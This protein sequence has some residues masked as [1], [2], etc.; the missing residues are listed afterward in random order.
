MKHPETEEHLKLKEI[1]KLKLAEWFQG[2]TLK[3]YMVAGYEADVYGI[4]KDKR[5]VHAEV[6]WSAGQYEKN[7]ISLLISDAHVKIAVF[8]PDSLKKYEREYEKVRIEQAK[9]GFFYSTPI[10]GTRLLNKEKD[11][12][13]NL[14]KE[15]LG[16]TNGLPEVT[17]SFSR[18]YWYMNNELIMR[19]I[20]SLNEEAWSNYPTISQITLMDKKYT[21]DLEDLGDGIGFRKEDFEP[22][23]IGQLEWSK[24]K[25]ILRF[26][27]RFN[28]PFGVK[29]ETISQFVLDPCYFEHKSPF[30]LNIHIQPKFVRSELESDGLLGLNRWQKPNIFVIGL[31]KQLEPWQ[32]MMIEPIV[33]YTSEDESRHFHLS[34]IE[35]TGRYERERTYFDD[36]YDRFGKKKAEKLEQIVDEELKK[37]FLENC[38]ENQEKA[39]D[40]YSL[41]GT[42]T[43][44][45]LEKNETDALGKILNFSFMLYSTE[46]LEKHVQESKANLAK[47]KDNYR[48]TLANMLKVLDPL[49]DL[50]DLVSKE[51]AFHDLMIRIL[52]EGKIE[53]LGK[54]KEHK[55]QFRVKILLTIEDKS[56]AIYL[57]LMDEE[58]KF[59]RELT[60]QKQKT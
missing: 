16:L 58:L 5:I 55:F 15:I 18:F 59:L 37:L 19:A 44:L 13:E 11:A 52:R 20:S 32:P 8:G 40:V 46:G 28:A 1:L 4:T 31:V 51:L 23:H 50:E 34:L 27:G 25:K 22:V 33:M 7:I 54:P 42:V 24:S 43:Q 41:Y 60:E 48:D 17:S 39:N 6:I 26:Y 49:F 21:T 3:E 10:D 30:S 36:L 47:L 14:H 57:E 12:F 53:I 45:T 35:K 9:K 29:E 56:Q 38:W 2:I